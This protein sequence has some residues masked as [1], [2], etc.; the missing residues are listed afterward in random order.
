LRSRKRYASGGY[1][2][3]FLVCLSHE[4]MENYYNTNF[5]LLQHYSYSLTELEGMIPWEREVYIT[6]LVQY[7]KEEKQRQEQTA[8]GS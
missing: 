6:M 3:F 5:Q 7:L 1:G 4:T 2:Q 8:R